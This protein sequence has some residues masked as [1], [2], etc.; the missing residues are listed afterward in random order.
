MEK[1]RL[2]VGCL[3]H[4]ALHMSQGCFIDRKRGLGK[5]KKAVDALEI[6]EVGFLSCWCLIS[7]GYVPLGSLLRRQC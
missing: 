2:V 6:I 4:A 5:G 7:A 3:F 1:S